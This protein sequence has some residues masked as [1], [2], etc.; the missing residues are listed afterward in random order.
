MSDQHHR[1]ERG[2]RVA[3]QLSHRGGG[4]SVDCRRRVQ[5]PLQREEGA[6][7]AI[8]PSDV[9]WIPPDV[10]HWHG[11]SP[12]TAMTHIAIQEALDGRIVDWL[13][14]VTDKQYAAP[15]RER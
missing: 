2:F 14:H 11:A 9:A 5:G 8:R 12:K 1:R 13:E 10:K 4:A 15:P 3:S 7:E 6:L